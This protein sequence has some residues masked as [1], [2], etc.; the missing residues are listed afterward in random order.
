MKS[1]TKKT[2]Y[3]ALLKK[4]ISFEGLFFAGIKTT[5][6]FCRPTCTA[7]KPH[8]NNVEFF[9][10]TQEALLNG[11]RPCKRC[12]PLE[13]AGE[14]PPFINTIL[15]QLNHNPT[16][17]IKDFDLVKMGIE[18][19]RVRRWFKIHHGI[20]FQGYQ[21]MLRINNA[22]KKLS[23]G[24]TV[25]TVAYDTGYESL[26]GFSSAYQ[27]IFS[28]A[29]SN[30]FTNVINITRFTTPLGPMFACATEEGICLLEFTERRMLEFEF[31]DI[32]KRLR[33]K[34]LY[35]NNPHFDTLQQQLKEYFDGK[36]KKFDIPLITPG[37]EFQQQVWNVLMKIPYG[38]T[39][40]YKEQAIKMKHIK[41]VR[42]VANANGYNRIAI[43]IP[44]H[45]VIGDDGNL[46]GYGGG[47]WRKQWLIDF[48]K[49]NQF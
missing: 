35:G 10:T 15:S 26:S 45:R 2:M 6:I 49:K 44:C 29:P 8:L 7:K 12:S 13:F 16:I 46:K 5:G 1:L 41:A 28:T 24:N 31:R 48:E 11:Y 36:R 25:T 9:T 42:A 20:T 23:Q 3:N 37:T 27:N 14:T 33:A 47:V 34:I 19:H 22:Y 30:N 39:I 38:K 43:I 17:K 40:S 21:R 18:P 32:Q 4:D